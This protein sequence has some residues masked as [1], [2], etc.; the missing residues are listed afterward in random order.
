MANNQRFGSLGFSRLARFEIGQVPLAPIALA[1][2][3]PLVIGVA[4]ARGWRLTWMARCTA[5]ILVFG[6]LAV[7][8]D[9]GTSLPEPGVLLV[10]VAF[11]LALAAAGSI[12]A[13]DEDVRGG[14][15]GWRQPVGVGSMLAIAVAVVPLIAN[16]GSGRWQAPTPE[17]AGVLGS[18]PTD[19]PSG[20]FRILYVGDARVL[21]LPGRP[22]R[23]GVSYAISDDG[24]LTVL[25]LW[26]P[27]ASSG[28]LLVEQALDSVSSNN[29]LRAGHLLA[30]LGI[31]YIVVPLIDGLQSSRSDPLPAPLGI[32]DAFSD[33]IDLKRSSYVSD[34]AIV[35]ENTEALPLRS[36]LNGATQ[37]ASQTAG[38]QALIQADYSDR[39][40]VFVGQSAPDAAAGPI[41]AGTF[42]DSVGN[43]QRWRLRVN[44]RSVQERSAFGWS[45]AYEVPDGGS[46]VLSYRTDFAREVMLLLQGILWLMVI[47]FTA[48]FSGWRRWLMRRRQIADAPQG[49]LIRLDETGSSPL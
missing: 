14:R 11:A 3:V 43:D 27:R 22:Y 9:A 47:A 4:L 23:D 2:F 39:S 40:P 10:P 33:Q 49:P 19:P 29:T 25:D 12:V 17:L 24:P 1:L 44:G 31:R 8:S 13:F 35:Y 42:H 38:A 26:Q 48:R 21:P 32:E 34:Q 28:D 5:L 15:I 30:P 45:T 16:M 41:P 37:V 18:L 20:D 7:A 46:A 6:A 36:V